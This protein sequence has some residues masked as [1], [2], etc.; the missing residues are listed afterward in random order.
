MQR[1][2]LNIPDKFYD[3]LKKFIKTFNDAGFQCYLVGGCVRDLILGHDIYDYDFATDAKPREVIKLFKRV[4]P[5]GVKHGTVTV[6][7]RG[8]DFEVTTFR[9]DG[10]YVD[11]RRPE[12]VHF[13]T[14]LEED[15]KRRDFTINGLAYDFNE[16]RIIDHVGG[17]DDL[18]RGIIRTIGSPMERFSEDGLRTFR[19]CRI[20][21]K[22]N[23]DIETA[24]LKAIEKTHDVARQVSVERIKDELM[25][26]L[27]SPKPSVGLEY[28]RTTGI[29]KLFL[30]EL[31]SCHGVEQNK[32]HIH[33]V[34]YHSLYSCDA[35]PM[36]RPRI[37]LA[38][39]LHDIGKVKTRRLGAGGDYTFYNHEVVGARQVRKLMRR[40]KF[41]NDDMDYV[42]NLVL[43]HMFHYTD[44]SQGSRPRGQWFKKRFARSHSSFTEENRPCH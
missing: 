12:E 2:E 30:P 7:V 31:D 5:T 19:A 33:D 40:L 4:I 35:A 26:L 14:S 21:S 39:L 8:M 36:D 43:N 27:E 29:L 3:D 20:A 28:M 16:D 24:T 11:G 10:K 44:H 13:A 37:R 38:A 41:S 25:K 1:K 42:E 23:F 32:Y 6:L 15:V 34:Y 18:E 17:R 9:A 22:L